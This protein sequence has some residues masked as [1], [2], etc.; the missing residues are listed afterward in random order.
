MK[1]AALHPDFILPS[2]G[3]ELA[4]AWD[5]YMPE[6]GSVDGTEQLVGLGFAA[7]V[8]PGFVAML[9]PRSGVGSRHGLE[10]NNTAGIIDADYRGEWQAALRTK[11]GLTF[12]WNKDD[13]LLQFLVLPIAQIVPQ[14]VAELA[15]SRRGAGGFGSSGQ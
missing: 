8:P 3:S 1:F 6:A 5:L 9:L 11:S 10:L 12:S 15:P 13:R 14:L 4:G 7:E 2:R